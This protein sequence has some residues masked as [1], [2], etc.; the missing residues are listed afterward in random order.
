MF[1][2]RFGIELE[3]VGLNGM[4]AAAII[5]NAGY[6]CEYEGY[7]HTDHANAWKVVADS[8]ISGTGCEVVSPILSG[9]SGLTD[10]RAVCEHLWKTQKF[11]VHDTVESWMRAQAHACDLAVSM[12]QNGQIYPVT[13][14]DTPEHL[15][16][17]MPRFNIL[18]VV[19]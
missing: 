18:R 2:K 12:V 1:N 11:A 8:S 5:R 7:N 6:S 13:R 17:D 19:N 14:Y 16:D 4:Q 3:I 15:V 9:E 10:A